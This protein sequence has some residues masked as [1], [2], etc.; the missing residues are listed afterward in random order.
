[1]VQAALDG[2]MTGRTT[3]VVAHR[4]ST[5]MGANKVRHTRRPG[6]GGGSCLG[7][8]AN[9]LDDVPGPAPKPPA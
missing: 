2:L 9:C 6:G 1:M 3:V 4:L 7:Q 5:V 8:S